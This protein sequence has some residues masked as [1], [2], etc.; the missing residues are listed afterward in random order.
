MS[1]D[2]TEWTERLFMILVF[3][4]L[5]FFTVNAR[6]CFEDNEKLYVE[7]LTNGNAV[8]DCRRIINVL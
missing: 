2:R 6:G 8:E 3:A 7:C 4:F 1:N 5:V